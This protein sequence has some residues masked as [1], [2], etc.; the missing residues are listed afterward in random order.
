MVNVTLCLNKKKHKMYLQMR[1]LVAAE[2]I[3]C[4]V[5]NYTYVPCTRTTLILSN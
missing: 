2:S 5:S 3:L 4:C 1:H